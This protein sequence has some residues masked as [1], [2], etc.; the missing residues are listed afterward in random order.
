MKLT[1]KIHN[2]IFLSKSNLFYN[3]SGCNSRTIF[4]LFLLYFHQFQLLMIFFTDRYYLHINCGGKEI[5]VNGT[6]FEADIEER[7]A[8]ELYLSTNWSFSSTGNFMDNDLD[9]DNY[10]AKNS[11][12]LSMPNSEL[13][14]RARLSPLSLTYYGLCLMKGSYTV[15]LHFAEIVFADDNTFR[16]LGMRVFNVF[17][18]VDS[19][20]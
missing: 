17:I 7:G 15:K 20:N 8:S 19:Y 12:E 1:V 18:Q 3:S 5:T 2:I 4:L 9:A 10:I 14:T 6:K 11:S 16:S 13:Y